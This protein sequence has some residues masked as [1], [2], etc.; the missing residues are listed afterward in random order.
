MVCWADTHAFATALFMRAGWCELVLRYVQC[1]TGYTI[2]RNIHKKRDV[3]ASLDFFSN[4]SQNCNFLTNPEKVQKKPW[5]HIF[6]M[7]A[8]LLRVKTRLEW[9]IHRIS[10]SPVITRTLPNLASTA[11]ALCRIGHIVHKHS[12]IA[13]APDLYENCESFK[14]LIETPLY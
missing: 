4:M 6:W 9:T 1:S 5:N 11:D 13:T 8:I 14:R 7:W 3:T 10:E 2:P 12:L